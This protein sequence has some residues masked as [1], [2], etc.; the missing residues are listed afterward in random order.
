MIYHQCQLK[1]RKPTIRVDYTPFNFLEQQYENTESNTT[2][3]ILFG[4][5]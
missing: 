4:F 5:V 1:V 3:Y 2:N